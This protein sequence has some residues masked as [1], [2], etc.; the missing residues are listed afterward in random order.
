MHLAS[1]KL[2]ELGPIRTLSLRI[3]PSRFSIFQ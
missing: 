1:Y 2:V 3:G